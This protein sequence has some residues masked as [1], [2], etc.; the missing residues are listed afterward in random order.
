M[1][2]DRISNYK[3]LIHLSRSSS[4]LPRN[5]QIEVS[6]WCQSKFNIHKCIWNKSK[7]TIEPKIYAIETPNNVYVI[8]IKYLFQISIHTLSTYIFMKNEIIDFRSEWFS[9]HLLSIPGNSYHNKAWYC[10]GNIRLSLAKAHLWPCLWEIFSLWNP[11][12]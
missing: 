4:W 5:P 12:T 7:L 9:C 3:R 11:I 1:N 10:I 6:W 8:I 2:E